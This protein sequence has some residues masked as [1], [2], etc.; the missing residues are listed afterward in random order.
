MLRLVP[1]RSRERLA[2]ADEDE[3]PRP[4]GIGLVVLLER[5]E[6]VPVGVGG[7]L[8]PR[9]GDR[10]PHGLVDL[11]RVVRGERRLAPDLGGPVEDLLEVLAPDHVLGRRQGHAEVDVEPRLLPDLADRRLRQR[12]PGFDLALGPRPVVVAGTVDEGDFDALGPVA[13]AH[14]AGGEDVGGDPR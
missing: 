4:Q 9:L 14:G 8:R 11:P 6:L 5:V 2:V 7:Q 3:R 12:L 10:Q 13:P 1:L